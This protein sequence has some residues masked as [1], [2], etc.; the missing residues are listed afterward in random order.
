[1]QYHRNKRG[2]HFE[3]GILVRHDCGGVD[4]EGL[5]WWELADLVR[6]ILKGETT[7]ESEFPNYRYSQAQWLAEALA[8]GPRQVI[9]HRQWS[10]EVAV[11]DGCLDYTKI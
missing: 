1:M 2:D 8:A 10:T 11:E 3:Q 7:L 5:S 6:R 9:S 4:P